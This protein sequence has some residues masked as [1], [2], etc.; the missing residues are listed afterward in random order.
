MFDGKNNDFMKSFA[1]APVL[2]ECYYEGEPLEIGNDAQLLMGDVL[3]EDVY[4]ITHEQQ[5]PRLLD[6]D[7]ILTFDEPWEEKAGGLEG[8]IYDEDE[9]LFKTW[10]R[11]RKLVGDP[12]LPEWEKNLEAGNVPCA[13]CYAESKDMLHWTKP[14]F[15]HCPIGEFKESNICFHG[16]SDCGAHTGRVFR[17]VDRADKENKYLCVYMDG[18][19]SLRIASSPD[20][21]VWRDIPGIN[22]IFPVPY[23]TYVHVIYNK[24]KGKYLLYMRPSVFAK[25]ESRPAEP[26]CINLN[27]RRRITVSESADLIH[28]S[29]PRIVQH[30]SE[31]ADMDQCD[32]QNTFVVGSHVIARMGRFKVRV[33]DDAINQK[34]KPWWTIG[35]D[36]YHMSFLDGDEQIPN[37]V[38][39][40]GEA[41]DAMAFVSGYPIYADDKV[42]FVSR[43]RRSKDGKGKRGVGLMYFRE[44]GYVAR[45]ADEYGG[46]L[47]TRE[48][49]FRGNELEINCE[50]NEGG[51]ITAEILFGDGG[52]IRGG[53]NYRGFTVE[54]CEPVTEESVHRV[55][56]WNGS[57]DLTEFRDKPV[58]IRFH[59]TNAKLYS[60]RVN[61]R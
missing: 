23:D 20:G 48:F 55:L 34:H 24:A 11:V 44:N 30:A 56:T 42:F 3:V 53:G 12:S 4:R 35:P 22:P 25:H 7:P 59:I 5:S 61:D 16:E 18:A 6:S 52:R 47:L 14:T 29:T 26:V 60:F 51:S 10:Y 28:W 15:T 46:W 40:N 32:N 2:T 33:Y 49:F 31:I 57:S 37:C 21:R 50:V 54:D 45:V 39:E 38:D 8:I 17:N 9:G 36:P 58:Y 13:L 1:F 43:G 19:T 41:T 27:Y